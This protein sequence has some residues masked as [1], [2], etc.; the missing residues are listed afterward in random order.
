MAFRR[1]SFR[2]PAGRA[3][4][5]RSWSFFVLLAEKGEF[6]AERGH[7]GVVGEGDALGFVVA[8]VMGFGQHFGDGLAAE[9]FS[10]GLELGFLHGAS[11]LL[12]CRVRPAIN[13]LA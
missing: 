4:C 3:R 1:R 6:C 7:F 13:G 5:R 11:L 2:S 10:R 9:F 12:P 8:V